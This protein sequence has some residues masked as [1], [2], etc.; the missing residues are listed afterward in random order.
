M[1]LSYFN[2]STRFMPV[3]YFPI[4]VILFFFFFFFFIC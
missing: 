3:A 4:I 2:T 1:L